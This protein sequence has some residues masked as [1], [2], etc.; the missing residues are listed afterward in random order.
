[1]SYGSFFFIPFKSKLFFHTQQIFNITP[2]LFH[3]QIQMHTAPPPAP[4]QL[5]LRATA[6]CQMTAQTQS[7]AQD[8]AAPRFSPF[9]TSLTGRGKLDSIAQALT[10]YLRFTETRSVSFLFFYLFLLSQAQ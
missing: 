4:P 2:S 1:M 3:P 7:S 6:T 8:P 9:W 5:S 10:Y